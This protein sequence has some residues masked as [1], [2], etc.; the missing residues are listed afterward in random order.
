MN[1]N[2]FII[3][4]FIRQNMSTSGLVTMVKSDYS[5]KVVTSTKR[6]K[7]IVAL[8]PLMVT[9]PHVGIMVTLYPF[10]NTVTRKMFVMG[11]EA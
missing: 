3:G 5:Q 7:S 4:E 9:I 1:K 6:D 11:V 8:H 10:F 2:Q